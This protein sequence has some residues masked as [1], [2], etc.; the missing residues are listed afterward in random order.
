[1]LIV[2]TFFRDRKKEQDH[3]DTCSEYEAMLGAKGLCKKE[4]NVLHEMA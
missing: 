1:M 3:G 4:E 2:I